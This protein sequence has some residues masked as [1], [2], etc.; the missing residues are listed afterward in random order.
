[1]R[2]DLI[3][4]SIGGD[5]QACRTRPLTQASVGDRLR[6]CYTFERDRHMQWPLWA[7]MRRVELRAATVIG[8]WSVYLPRKKIR[9]GQ[10]ATVERV[11]NGRQTCPPGAPATTA[12]RAA[13]HLSRIVPRIVFAFNWKHIHWLYVSQLGGCVAL[14]S[15]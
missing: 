2:R 1:M 3:E 7:V 8:D 9:S 4:G 13:Q 10:P 11:G 15:I 5:R 12:V 6:R 14:T